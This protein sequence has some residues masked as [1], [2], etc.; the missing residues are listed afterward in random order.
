MAGGLFLFPNQVM[1]TSLRRHQGLV[2]DHC[3]NE[4][5]HRYTN[6]KSTWTI[7]L[8]MSTRR[9]RFL[10]FMALTIGCYWQIITSSWT[11]R[12][13]GAKMAYCLLEVIIY[14]IISGIKEL[15]HSFSPFS[16]PYHILHISPLLSL[17][18]PCDGNYIASPIESDRS[19]KVK[20]TDPLKVA[21]LR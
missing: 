12:R 9:G 6:T 11:F 3:K 16:A 8:A 14:L 7:A 2:L 18:F 15:Y 10:V 4:H 5:R 19:T 13:R 21:L 20:K 1:L 17:F